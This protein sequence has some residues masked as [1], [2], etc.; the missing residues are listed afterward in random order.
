[1]PRNKRKRKKLRDAIKFEK[2]AKHQ[3]AEKKRLKQKAHKAHMKQQFAMKTERLR[4][5]A[6]K[7]KA[8]AIEHQRN[9]RERAKQK[10]QRLE[11][12]H[13][14]MDEHKAIKKEKLALKKIAQIEHA[15]KSALDIAAAITRQQCSVELS[16]DA[17]T[18]EET[19]REMLSKHGEIEW[20]K[21]NIRGGL[22]IRYKTVQ[23][24][25][26]LIR[27][28]RSNKISAEVAFPIAPVVIKQH[29]LYFKPEWEIDQ[30]VLNASADFF[31]AMAV[32]QQI[33]K[34][35]AAVLVVFEDQAT[36]DQTVKDSQHGRW[37]ICG[38]SIGPCFAGLPPYINKRKARARL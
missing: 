6:E 22:D 3:A 12:H 37:K 5:K 34:Y 38:H 11:K 14:M 25:K 26:N 33:K 8:M 7:Q 18:L 20:M 21:K 15:K 16:F 1:M 13:R 30:E 24:A 28:K 31:S 23:G 36:R 17:L 10:A 32:V 27:S 29:A 19:L 2:K 4:L 35:R 9:Q